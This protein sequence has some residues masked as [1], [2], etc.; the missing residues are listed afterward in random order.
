MSEEGISALEANRAWVVKQNLAQYT[1]EWIAVYNE[2]II[3]KGRDL[4]EV[5]DEVVKKKVGREQPLY[6]RV[7]EGLIV[8]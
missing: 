2:N 1:G 5:M 8:T 4:G 6:M 7:P 3:A